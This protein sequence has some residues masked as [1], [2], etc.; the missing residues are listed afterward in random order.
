[1]K[2]LWML[3]KPGAAAIVHAIDRGANPLLVLFDRV[4]DLSISWIS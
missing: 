3:M 4:I 1:M 2:P